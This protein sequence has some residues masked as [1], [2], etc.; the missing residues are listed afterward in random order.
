[1]AAVFYISS[2]PQNEIR[3]EKMEAFQQ[4]GKSIDSLFHEFGFGVLNSAWSVVR[5]VFLMRGW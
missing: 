3:A 5:D 4:H 2:S 1:M